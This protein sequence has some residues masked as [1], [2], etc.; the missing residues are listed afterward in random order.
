M[1]LVELLE[2]ER[3]GVARLLGTSGAVLTLGA[4]AAVLAL[5]TLLLG[6]A[7][8]LALPR[9]VP[10][11]L[12]LAVAAL[13]IVAVRAVRSRL[14]REATLAGVAGAVERERALRDGSLRG[15]V[16]VAASGALGRLGAQQMAERLAT[17][18]EKSLVPSLHRRMARAVGVGALAAVGALGILAATS[19]LAPDGWAALMHPVRAWRGTL[20]EGV[21]LD[22]VPNAVLRGERL[23]ITVRAP[24]RRAVSILHRRTGDAWRESVARVHDGQ[25]LLRLDPVESDLTIVATDGRAVSDTAL[26]RMV[27]RPFIGDVTVRAQFP[28]YLRRQEEIIPLGEPARLPQG[29][30]LAFDGQ[31]STEL[32]VVELVQG[33]RVIAMEES[34][35]RFT[36]RLTVSASGRYEWKA[37][38]AA[39][40]IAD[41]PPPLDLEVTPDSAPQIDIISPANDTTVSEGDSLTVS[42]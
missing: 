12:W 28:A 7:R 18:K 4:V 19:A 30:V 14:S 40:P 25:A 37:A 11:V 16:E 26:V 27:E 3:R 15:T 29:T 5:G 21:R 35:R 34:G 22:G 38:G 31:S 32:E 24:G 1:N 2:R 6:G 17:S 8:W 41:V 20:L 33:D 39:G 23:T 9:P 10:I 42:V 36:G 13:V